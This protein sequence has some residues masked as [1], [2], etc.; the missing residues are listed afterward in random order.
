VNALREFGPYRDLY[1]FDPRRVAI[2]LLGGDKTGKDRW[3]ELNVPRAE[4]IYDDFLSE[5]SR[6]ENGASSR[7]GTNYG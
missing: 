6:E 5:L 4:K 2:L 7:K 3:Y 1:A